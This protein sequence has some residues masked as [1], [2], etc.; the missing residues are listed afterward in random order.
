MVTPRDGVDISNELHRLYGVSLS[1]FTSTRNEIAKALAAEGHKAEAA[2]VKSLKKP[3]VAVWAINQLARSHDDL[4]GDLLGAKADLRNARS[5]TEMRAA[6]DRRKR[7]VSA[8]ITVAR[9]VLEEGGHSA[10]GQTLD[11]VSRAL[12]TA[13]DDET[14]SQMRLGILE[15]EPRAADLDDD[16]ESS[17]VEAVSSQGDQKARDDAERLADAA[18]EAER[19]AKEARWE[20][21]RARDEAQRLARVADSAEEKAERA[22]AK[23]DAALERLGS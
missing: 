4:M 21:D 20:A 18:E 19:A 2:A 12:L 16:L 6:V 8:L 23:A 9:D 11:A 5:G 15:G 17:F 3:S 10:S 7:A 22:R 1:D 13:T 14:E